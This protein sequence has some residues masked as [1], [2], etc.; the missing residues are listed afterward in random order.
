[1]SAFLVYK[2]SVMRRLLALKA[3]YADFLFTTRIL[4][5]DDLYL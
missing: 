1:M 3:F 2:L 5:F 4:A